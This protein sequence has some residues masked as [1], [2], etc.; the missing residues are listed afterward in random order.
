MP[1]CSTLSATA[2]RRL[3]ELRVL[4]CERALNKWPGKQ[5]FRRLPAAMRA[6]RRSRGETSVRKWQQA[7]KR[8]RANRWLCAL[9]LPNSAGSYRASVARSCSSSKPRNAVAMRG[10]RSDNRYSSLYAQ[11]TW[12]LSPSAPSRDQSPADTDPCAAVS[13][14]TSI[15][16]LGFQRRD[17]QSAFDRC[18]GLA[19]GPAAAIVDKICVATRKQTQFLCRNTSSMPTPQRSVSTNKQAVVRPPAAITEDCKR[20]P[21][22]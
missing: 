8:L 4:F 19:P 18:S 1:Q 16:C 17:R 22:Q 12:N 5:V 9:T 21:S 7:A 13:A 15:A 10:R 20:P 11:S 14:A 6:L 3:I 2:E